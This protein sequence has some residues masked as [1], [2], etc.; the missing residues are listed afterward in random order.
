[1]SL[2]VVA[3]L[4]RRVV[5]WE[6]FKV[7]PSLRMY[8]LSPI[9]WHI[10]KGSVYFC[11]MQRF[12]SKHFVPSLEG[13]RTCTLSEIYVGFSSS[14]VGHWLCIKY[15]SLWALYTQ[16]MG[17]TQ[18][19]WFPLEQFIWKWATSGMQS[20]VIDMEEIF[21]SAFPLLMLLN[22][23]LDILAHSSTA[24]WLR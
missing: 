22:G 5:R 14:V 21:H 6:E 9:F 20:G 11:G 24:Q 15:P 7:F 2:S 18:S 19:V 12:L 1:M 10:I 3:A 23:Q 16:K 8:V 4:T 17:P 13:R